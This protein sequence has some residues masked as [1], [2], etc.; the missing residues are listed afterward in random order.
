MNQA[1]QDIVDANARVDTD[2]FHSSRH[3]DG[4]SFPEG[5]ALITGE[6]ATIKTDLANNDT[7]GARFT[8]GQALHTIQDFYSHSNWVENNGA[9]AN[10]SLGVPNIIIGRLSQGTATCLA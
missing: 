7:A 6:L 5:Q 10:P 2:Q 8:L 1:I 9:S 3:F 4:E